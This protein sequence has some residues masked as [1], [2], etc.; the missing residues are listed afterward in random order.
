MLHVVKGD[1]LRDLGDLDGAQAAYDQ[2]LEVGPHFP[3]AR[4]ARER[5]R[6][7]RWLDWKP[8]DPS[9]YA[10]AFA[11]IAQGAKDAPPDSPAP[12]LAE[13]LL[14]YRAGEFDD[15]VRFLGSFAKTHAFA[16]EI[17]QTARLAE[18]AREA[19]GAERGYRMA[20]ERKG[21]LPRVRLVTSKGAAVYE[22]FEDQVPNTVANF[23]WLAK[24][25]FYDG[26][27]LDKATPFAALR[28]GDPFSR[29]GA[30][31]GA[32][33]GTGGPGWAIPSEPKRAVRKTDPQPAWRRAFRGTIATN[34]D[35]PDTA[36]SRFF[37][38]TGTTAFPE[39]QNTV[40]GRVVEGQD[41][42]ERLV[43]G[44]VLEKVEVLRTREHDYRPTTV[45]G[46]PAPAPKAVARR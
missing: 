12:A 41:V 17:V 43:A 2:A 1:T 24:H 3:E 26:T 20:D 33:V 29:P 37:L 25:G 27:R 10:A 15:A 32:E 36:G 35:G 39:G 22:L 9:D 7:A 5:L 6:A 11:R 46:E 34:D 42:V 19:W 40:F 38:V 31:A 23:V 30:E 16:E 8:S 28:G 44:D 14:R 13:G 45:A 4:W 18:Q 21:D